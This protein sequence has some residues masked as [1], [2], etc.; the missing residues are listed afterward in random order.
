[1][2]TFLIVSKGEIKTSFGQKTCD[3][4]YDAGPEPIDLPIM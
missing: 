3:A 4:R 2:E 1:M